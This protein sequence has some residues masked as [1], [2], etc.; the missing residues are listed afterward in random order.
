MFVS[1]F[2]CFV[3]LEDCKFSSTTSNKEQNQL[4]TKVQQKNYLNNKEKYIIEKDTSIF[5][6]ESSQIN[7]KKTKQFATQ[8]RENSLYRKYCLI[9]ILIVID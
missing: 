8:R 9:E 5:N 1:S 7:R 2:Y 4:T 3:V 6:I